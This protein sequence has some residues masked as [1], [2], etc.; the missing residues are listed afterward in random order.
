MKQLENTKRF[1]EEYGLRVPIL[2]A[3][4]AGACTPAL[5]AA[6]SNAGGMGACGVLMLEPHQIKDWTEKFT[7]NF[8]GPSAQR[9][10][11]IFSTCCSA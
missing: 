7:F 4:M 2:M 6:V 5:A 9:P 11:T 1:C 10:R 8:G 3:P